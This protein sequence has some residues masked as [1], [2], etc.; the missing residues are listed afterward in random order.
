[1]TFSGNPGHGSVFIQNSAAE[2]LVG[3]SRPLS[4]TVGCLHKMECCLVIMKIF[5]VHM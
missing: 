4:K 2:K 3:F 1:V 5:V